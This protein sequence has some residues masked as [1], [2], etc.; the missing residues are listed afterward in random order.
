MKPLL[1]II[2]FSKVKSVIISSLDLLPSF[3]IFEDIYNDIKIDIMYYQFSSV[4]QS[5]LTLCDPMDFRVPGLPVHHQ[6]M[7]L[8]Q[9][10]VHWVGDAIQ[11][12]HPLSNPSPPAFNLSQHRGLFQWVS[13]SHQVAKLLELQHQSFQWMFRTD[14]LYGGLV[15]SP[16]SPR[17]SQEFCPAPQFKSINSSALSFLYGSTLLNDIFLKI[18]LVWTILKIF[19]FVTIL[20]LISVFIFQLWGVWDLSSPTRD[21]TCTPCVGRW[22]L[23]HW[24]A[25]EVP[26]LTYSV[27]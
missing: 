16:C 26:I 24:T 6:L 11:P 3:L 27:D 10:H 22:S 17:D 12:S 4:T 7:Q 13:F 2:E 1:A 8:A 18:F 20:L 9:T 19:E 14:F 21:G 23:N 25:R 5:C 15:D